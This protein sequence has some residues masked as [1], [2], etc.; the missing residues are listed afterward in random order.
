MFGGWP[1]KAAAWSRGLVP[2]GWRARFSRCTGADG[3]AVPREMRPLAPCIICG[4]TRFTR[5]RGA[6][7][8]SVS[9]RLPCCAHCNSL[10]RHRSAR[11]VMRQLRR[12]GLKQAR[13]LQI[14]T[15]PT[16]RASWFG[17][18]EVSIY[19]QRN[20]LDVQNIARAD[21]S[22]DVVICNHVI[23]HVPDHRRAVRELGRILSDRGFLFLSVPDPAH[24]ARTEDWGRPDPARHGHY[25]E[26][27]ADFG[28]L[29]TMELP[30]LSIVALRT[31]DDTTGDR[32]VI[33]ILTRNRTW[34]RRVRQLP[35]GMRVLARRPFAA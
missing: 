13:C 11:K 20:S 6:K 9:G 29:L 32:D 25:R 31:L 5:W 14:S 24:R 33:Y 8:L 7:P 22:Y 26:F 10:P 19:D 34:Y 16:A 2:A 15:D 3:K 30:D 28:D 27:G 21:K 17:E 4:G 35:F 1:G 12:K 23:E 18:R